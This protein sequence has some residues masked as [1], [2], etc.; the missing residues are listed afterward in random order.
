[1]SR[2]VDVLLFIGY[3]LRSVQKGIARQ[4]VARQVFKWVRLTALRNIYF[5]DSSK[6]RMLKP[7][8]NSSNNTFEFWTFFI[9]FFFDG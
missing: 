4:L 2:L 1:M 9:L 3:G 6:R 8:S 5:S 7:M